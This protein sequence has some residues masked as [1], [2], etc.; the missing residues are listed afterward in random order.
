[1]KALAQNALET[2]IVEHAGKQTFHGDGDVRLHSRPS[3]P[4]EVD[5]IKLLEGLR[6]AALHSL[7]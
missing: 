7:S 1:M 3:I 6:D 4:A 2:V 5:R